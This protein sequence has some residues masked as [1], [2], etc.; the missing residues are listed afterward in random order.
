M[1]LSE[2]NKDKHL[3]IL[4]ATSLLTS[5]V[6]AIIGWFFPPDFSVD[7]PK[8]NKLGLVFGHLQTAFVILGCT[9][10]GI[11]LAEEKQTLASIGFT[12]M[13]ITQGI[14]FVLYV[15]SPEPSKENLDEVYK[16][17]S[18]SLFLLIPSMLL[19]ALYSNFPKWLNIFG[20][21]STIP[22]LI[23]NILYFTN[24]KL[25][26]IEGAIDFLGQLMI[27]ITVAAWAIY[28][29]KNNSQSNEI[30]K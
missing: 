16:L 22:W 25:T 21:L 6:A 18:A 7:P 26:E 24:H 20:M 27:N 19:I 8:I 9:A 15:I 23:E 4:I 3:R 11:K 2:E 13:A 28:V 14:I 30:N 12:M 10:L 29:L 5:V 17:F 1:Y